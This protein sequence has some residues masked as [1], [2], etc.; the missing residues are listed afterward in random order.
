MDANQR[1]TSPRRAANET[2]SPAGVRRLWKALEH[3]LQLKGYQVVVRRLEPSRCGFTQHPEKLVVISDRLNDVQAVA[4]LAHE[5]GHV[6]LHAAID[7]ATAEEPPAVREIEAELFAYNVLSFNGVKPGSEPFEHI[8]RWAESVEPQ[9]PE[10][11]VERLLDRTKKTTRS[12]RASVARHMNDH[13]SS[14]EPHS[15]RDNFSH[16]APDCDGPVF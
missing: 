1:A 14:V 6:Y 12:L 7:E 8:N 16:L 3:H 13:P 5:T 9:T 2:L 10:H 11:V 15:S 4:R